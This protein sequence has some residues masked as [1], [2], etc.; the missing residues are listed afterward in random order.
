MS[1]FVTRAQELGRHQQS[2][3]TALNS[4]MNGLLRANRT[5]RGLATE[6]EGKSGYVSEIRG[7]SVAWDFSLNP[8]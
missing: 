2:F 1:L 6:S 3:S 7:G 5:Q 8:D 4:Q